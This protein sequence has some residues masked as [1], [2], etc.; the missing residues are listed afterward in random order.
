MSART[1]DVEKLVPGLKVEGELPPRYNIAPSQEIAA[2]LNDE[3]NELSMLRW[4]LVPS[5]AKDAATVNPI[6]NARSETVA[7]KPS[8]RTPFKKRRCLIIADGYYE[9][10]KAKGIKQK[11][12]YFI[13]LK[14]SQPFAF[15]GLWDSWRS[16]GGYELLSAAILTTE[17]NDYLSAI[18]NRMPVILTPDE[19]LIWLGNS[20][21]EQ[22]LHSG[23]LKAYPQDSMEAYEVSTY[24]N[25]PV[26]DGPQCIESVNPFG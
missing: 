1:K 26:N 21:S 5:W 19:S 16:P 3:K 25:S 15:A 11:I 23:L 20:P 10:R 4:G 2:V 24:V 14:S 17:P 18:H 22:S 9:W 6:I 7:Q 8:F 13:K 12:P